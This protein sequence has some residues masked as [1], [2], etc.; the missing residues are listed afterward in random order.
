VL[1]LAMTASGTHVAP[2]VLLQLKDQIA[3]HH[4]P[5]LTL[6]PGAAT[7]EGYAFRQIFAA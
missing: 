3:N 4:A 7:R 2:P 1:E 6:A 5:T